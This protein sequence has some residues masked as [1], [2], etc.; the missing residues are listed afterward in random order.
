[1]EHYGSAPGELA[2]CLRNVGVTRRGDCR[3]LLV[4]GHPVA[5]DRAVERLAA[6]RLEVGGAV[7][8]ADAWWCRPAIERVLVVCRTASRARLLRLLE[9]HSRHILGLRV[10]ADCRLEVATF[11]GR[12]L[13]ELLGAVNIYGDDGD[14]RTTPP[15]V[16][17]PVAGHPV[18]WILESD[19][20]VTACM[21]ADHA[22]A[23][24]RAVEE[25]GRTLGL[26]RIG[27]RAFDHF[28]LLERQRAA[29]VETL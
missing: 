5:I 1:M 4:E 27:R 22:D 21:D 11:L 16:V 23:V 12:R 15:C 18:T 24:H 29:R 19:G 8:L 9:R 6:V 28:V 17:V 2:A 10:D 3:T 14:P 26:A 7:E 20:M 25:A 13:Q